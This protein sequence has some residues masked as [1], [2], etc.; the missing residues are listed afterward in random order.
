MYKRLY[1]SIATITVSAL[2]LVAAVGVVG[3]QGQPAADAST[4]PSNLSLA[5]NSEYV[6]LTWTPSSNRNYSRHQYVWSWEDGNP[7]KRRGAVIICMVHQ[8]CPSDMRYAAS[9]FEEGKTYKFQVESKQT[10]DDGNQVMDENRKQVS[11]GV[12]NIVSYT[13]PKVEEETEEQQAAPAEDEDELEWASGAD[14]EKFTAKQAGSSVVLNWLPGND[15]GASHQ[16]I[17]RR[18]PRKG[19]VTIRVAA[20]ARTYTDTNVKAGKKYIYRIENWKGNKKI[21]LSRP[22]S[23]RVR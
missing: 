3:A 9:E 5:S 4:A 6:T 22:A 23:V 2:L 16:D 18:E 21:G 20:D 14:P 12:S 19:W 10:D 13:A 8:T 1:R 15:R 11:G 17:K 7:N